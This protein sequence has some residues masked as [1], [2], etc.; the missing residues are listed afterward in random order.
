MTF[1]NNNETNQK[2]CLPYSGLENPL[3]FAQDKVCKE[4]SPSSPP[5]PYCEPNVY[6]TGANY[7]DPENK[8]PFPGYACMTPYQFLTNRNYKLEWKPMFIV[9]A[10]SDEDVSEALKFASEHNIGVAVK[11][12]GHDFN[13]RNAGPTDNSMLIV[14]TCFRF[15][16]ITSLYDNCFSLE[17]LK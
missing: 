5:N 2:I 7:S 4:V 16:L 10:M 3:E 6:N 9:V 15:V 14:T 8:N 11:A 13:D 17:N 12:T 1:G